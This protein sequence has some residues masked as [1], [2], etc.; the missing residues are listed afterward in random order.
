MMR[1]SRH[2][3]PG[4]RD[5]TLKEERGV[6]HVWPEIC[7]SENQRWFCTDQAVFCRRV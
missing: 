2:T 4:R 6:Y 3:L 7:L 1:F 5:E